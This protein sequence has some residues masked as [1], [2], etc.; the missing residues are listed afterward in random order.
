MWSSACGRTC[1]VTR[2]KA[3]CGA[4]LVAAHVRLRVVKAQ[5]EPRTSGSH[6]CVHKWYHKWFNKAPDAM[7]TKERRAKEKDESRKEKEGSRSGRAS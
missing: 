7:K 5:V 3:T 4:S 2:R 6:K 1:G